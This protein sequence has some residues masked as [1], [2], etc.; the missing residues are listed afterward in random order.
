MKQ[1]ENVM[2]SKKRGRRAKAVNEITE[3]TKLKILM[4]AKRLFGQ[5]G[6]DRTGMAEIAEAADV[7]K[8]LLFYYFKSKN[9]LL[10]AVF[11]HFT[12]EAVFERTR[13]NREDPPRITVKAMEDFFMIIMKLVENNSDTV[14]ILLAEAFKGSSEN[15]YLF[16]FIRMVTGNLPELSRQYDLD[17]EQIRRLSTTLVFLDILP[18]LLFT[19]LSQKWSLYSGVEMEKVKNDFIIT[20]K[21]MVIN[22][23]YDNYFSEKEV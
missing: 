6:F 7:D 2:R 15:P 12:S 11:E 16:E 17:Q 22:H 20:F 3:T 9:N 19:A 13:K 10:K 4:E 18:I 23:L 5:K 14:N 1:D 8:A 21:E